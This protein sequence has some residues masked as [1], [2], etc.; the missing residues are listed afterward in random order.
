MNVDPSNP[1]WRSGSLHPQQGHSSIAP[2][3]CSLCAA[4]SRLPSLTRSMRPTAVAR[5]PGHACLPG[6]EMSTGSPVRGFRRARDGAGGCAGTLPHW[7][8]LGDGEIQEGQ[9]WE[10]VFMAARYQA[11]QSHGHPGL[12]RSAPV[13]LAAGGRVHPGEPIDDPGAKFRAF[14]WHVIECDGHDQASIREAFAARA[15]TGSRPASSLTP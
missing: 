15:F 9:I 4:T 12:Q 7:V 1:D 5:P 14:G 2:T 3:P 8:M 13:R 6:L 11:R 10:A